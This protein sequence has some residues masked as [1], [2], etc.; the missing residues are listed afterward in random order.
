M[1]DELAVNPAGTDLVDSCDCGCD[2]SLLFFFLILAIIFKNG[3]LNTSE[4]SLLFFF[5]LLAIIL[6]S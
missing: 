6:C 1:V 4:D 3:A 5:L 2:D